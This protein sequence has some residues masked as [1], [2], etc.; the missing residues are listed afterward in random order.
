MR[1]Q[2]YKYAPSIIPK[3]H[4]L[5]T[6]YAKSSNCIG[7]EPVLS[8]I[9]WLPGPSTHSTYSIPGRFRVPGALFERG[10]YFLITVNA[11]PSIREGFYSSAYGTLYIHGYITMCM[12]SASVEYTLTVVSELQWLAWRI[13][14]ECQLDTCHKCCSR[15]Y[16]CNTLIAADF[17]DSAWHVSL[18]WPLVPCDDNIFALVL[19]W[20]L[21]CKIEAL[22]QT[23]SRNWVLDYIYAC[24]T[25]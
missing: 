21:I 15:H 9:T 19:V 24:C 2:K 23:L 13:R 14:R 11:R 3:N 20:Y 6:S 7:K 8:K 1:E 10:F 16:F 25:V 22:D 12:W 18:Q 17:A 5:P 4:Q